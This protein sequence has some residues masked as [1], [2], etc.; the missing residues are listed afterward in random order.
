MAALE[1]TLDE[2]IESGARD[3]GTSS[4]LTVEQ[5]RIDLFA[6]ATDDYQWIHVD[7]DRAREGP[8]GTTVAHGYL[9]LSL[10]PHLFAN[11][12]TITDEGR[13]I[14]YGVDRVRFL[15]PVREGSD[16]R[17]RGRLKD[18]YQREDGGVRFNLVFEIEIRDRERPALVG[19][20]IYL[21]YPA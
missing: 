6:S 8:F 4:W 16:L 10:V 7:P 5:E 15:S 18:V 11:L 2:L 14:N 21:R 20:V 12:L 9:T 3:L 19:E 13:G 1:L 17:M